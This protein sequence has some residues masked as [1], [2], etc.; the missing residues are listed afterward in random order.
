MAEY[1]NAGC[2]AKPVRR[3]ERAEAPN[4]LHAN[5]RRPYHLIGKPG[6]APD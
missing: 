1:L 3:K 2:P 6:F 5:F 4:L